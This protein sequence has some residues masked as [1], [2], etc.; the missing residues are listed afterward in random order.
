MSKSYWMKDQKGNFSNAQEDTFDLAKRY[1]GIRLQQGV[2]LLDR[3]WNELED[4]RRYEEV[5]LRK[6][7]IG[8]G[9]PDDGFKIGTVTP[10]ANDF[11]ISK[12]RCM[13]D[14]FEI[15]NGQDIKYS[16]QK[17]YELKPPSHGDRMDTVYLDVWIEEITSAEDSALK[18]SED[19]NIE[20]C[21]RH[22]LKWRVKVDEGSSGYTKE[23]YHHYY[24]IARIKRT[25]DSTTI[26]NRDVMDLRRTGLAISLLKDALST[27]QMAD[28]HHRHSKLVGRDG[29]PDPALSVDNAG[30]VGIGTTSPRNP[31]GIRASG[32]SEDL[33]SFE[34]P[35]G[36]PK[37]HINQNLNGNK[38]GLNFVETGVADG[39]LFIQ[40]GG[41]VGIGTTDPEAKLHI[42]G[43]DLRISGDF[44][45]PNTGGGVAVLT[46]KTYDN[47]EGFQTNNIKFKLGSTHALVA[48]SYE[49]IVGHTSSFLFTVPEI[50]MV[51][52][53]IKRFSINQF[54]DIYNSGSKTGYV[55]DYFVNRVG[56]TVEEGDVVVISEYPVSHYSGNKNNIPVPEVDLTDK[57]YDTRACGIVAK[58]VTEKELPYVEV[59]PET[60]AEPKKSKKKITEKVVVP[61]KHPLQEFAAKSS[62]T[63]DYTKVQ[64]KQMGT[65]VTLGAFAHCKV[66]ADI[67]PIEV[68]DLLTTSPTK[69]HAQKVLESGNAIG[70]I[71][72]KAL[73]SLKK[74]KG[75]IPILVMLQ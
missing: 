18:N 4:I 16:E 52:N 7:Y 22:K 3:D 50:H 15:V 62:D 58:V 5:I 67:A 8:N 27:N 71:L 65:M 55:V 38:P 19:V 69:G 2:P 37:W 17:G 57:A 29:S 61:S 35:N 25:A 41:N 54:G 9:T 72:G 53:F 75:K 66:D 34:D 32:V 43:G 63:L 6:W 74:G 11:K 44:E 59:E 14:G 56:D 70:A 48:P 24:D 23:E 46:N 68:G 42:A 10:P 20:T 40:A 26:H 64:D 39:R 51:T 36:N 12:G 60:Q 73:G 21:V 1:V 33:I 30:N 45:F 13:V 49:F 28:A 31:L 47:E